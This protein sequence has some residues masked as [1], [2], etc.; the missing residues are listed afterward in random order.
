MDNGVWESRNLV[1]KIL[2]NRSNF[3]D[4]VNNQI[5]D[6]VI[7][8][9]SDYFDSVEKNPLTAKQ[10]EAVA[11]DEDSTLIIAGAGTGK[12]STIVAKIGHLVKSGQCKPEEILAISYTNKSANELME[13]VRETLNLEVSVSTFH[14]L[15]MNILAKAEMG[16]PLLVDFAADPVQKAHFIE[17]LIDE[18]KKNKDF[19]RKLVEFLVLYR[20]ADK[21]IWEFSSLA[22]YVNWLRSNNIVSLDGIRKKSYQECLI[23]NWLILNG[24][25]FVYEKS[26]KYSTKTVEHSQYCPDFYLIDSD[27]YIEHFGI[28]KNGKT[29]PY[30]NNQIYLEGMQ[31]KRETHKTCNTKLIETFSWEFGS[32]VLFE[33]LDKQLK[34]YGC[35]FKPTSSDEAL[36]LLN[37][38]GHINGFSELVASFLTLYK[39]NDNKLAKNLDLDD[40]NLAR[41]KR[42]LELFYQIL[43][44]YEKQ[45]LSNGRI[46]FE[47]MI[48]LATKSINNTSFNSPYKY[49]LIDE[50]QDISTG[51]VALIKALQKNVKD[52]A[53]FAVGDDW[54]S[55]YRFAGS[56]IG[57]MTKFVEFFGATRQVTLETTFRFSNEAAQVSGTF[58]LKNRAQI[59]KTLTSINSL[60]EPSLVL[61]KTDVASSAKKGF[62]EGPLDWILADIESQISSN[63]KASVL[64]LERYKFHLP[65]RSL[66]DDLQ[67]KFPKLLLI[68][69]GQ[70][71]TLSIHAAKGLEA[72]YV[73][74]G[75]RGGSWGFPSQV[76]DDPLLNLVLTQA[77]DYLFGEERRLFYV[78]ITRARYKTYLACETGLA[79]SIFFDELNNSNEYSVSV[80][81]VNTKK[82]LCTK[83]QSGNMLLRDGINGQFYG[84]SNFP[85]CNHSEQTCT[86][87]RKGFLV[88]EDGKAW[89]CHICG[90]EISPCPKCKMGILKLKNGVNGA[91]YGCS[92]FSDPEIKCRYT[93]DASKFNG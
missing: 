89:T 93:I 13:R 54:Q 85:H 57:V 65:E 43:E 76:I 49:I 37:H 38:A 4:F 3:R 16:K 26:Y 1:K 52:C 6:E 21:Q 79:Q 91:F 10:R 40:L 33:N 62:S 56:D 83:C 60:K 15:G 20:I 19:E 34:S 18:L 61:H 46:D 31:W 39:G 14:K 9:N 77:D 7:R 48:S 44:E 2:S 35:V 87:C 58:I 11:S 28:D 50:F 92:N 36:N 27:I 59:P 80:S 71:N 70:L 90:F 25:P 8:K 84:C 66:L 51:R 64:I 23:A 74:V 78:A 24:I 81:G 41:E 29:A 75:L 88:K 53:I 30:I 68:N 86:K 67:K 22:E 32:G 69:E 72:D 17:T 73:I 47:D 55:I 42:F 45:N 63:K 82:L 12:T 5:I